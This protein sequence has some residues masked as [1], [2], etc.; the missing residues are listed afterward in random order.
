M[1]K[2]LGW[3]MVGVGVAFLAVQGLGAWL[4]CT[5]PPEAAV[6]VAAVDEPAPPPRPIA[7]LC[8][9]GGSWK[10]RV[11]VN[12]TYETPDPGAAV[13]L[14]QRELT[15]REGEVT[16]VSAGAPGTSTSLNGRLLTGQDL[17]W[18]SAL[19][20]GR[21]T[22]ISNSDS[23]I[24]PELDAACERLSALER[25]EELAIGG[26]IGSGDREA[27]AVALELIRNEVNNTRARIRSLALEAEVAQINVYFNP[28]SAG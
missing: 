6:E 8:D 16:Y 28:V 2:A 7:A 10:R 25:A 27:T 15:R 18:I 1:V 9:G 19:D 11:Y 3:S 4:G 26:A 21:V 20:V 12:V 14:L 5:V 24:Q 17:G 23:P 22:G 13:G